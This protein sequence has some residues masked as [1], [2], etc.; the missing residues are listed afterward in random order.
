MKT[1]IK[2]PV[3]RILYTLRKRVTLGVKELCFGNYNRF[4]TT[5][6]IMYR[7]K[8][9]GLVFQDNQPIRGES[10]KMAVRAVFWLTPEG[11]KIADEIV[12]EV[13]EYI[14]WKRYI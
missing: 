9:K 6:Q 3:Q 4:E 14:E 8:K 12:K 11:I 5:R 2:K 10:N 13:D 1:L 7:L